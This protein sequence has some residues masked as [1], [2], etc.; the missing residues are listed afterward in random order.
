LKLGNSFLIALNKIAQALLLACSIIAFLSVILRYVFRAPLFWGEEATVILLVWFVF[1]PQGLLEATDEQLCM[2]AL[3]RAVPD[4]VR[5]MLDILRF[6]VTAPFALY[7]AFVAIGVVLRNF[8]N[9]S[10]TA[11]LD[12][13]LWLLYLIICIAL[14]CIAIGRSIAFYKGMAHRGRVE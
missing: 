5:W 13:P 12:I 9:S 11:A 4:K 1:L 10:R 6:A 8:I 2:T 3:Y 14:V 7:L